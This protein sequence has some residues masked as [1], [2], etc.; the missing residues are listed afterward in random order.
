MLPKDFSEVVEMGFEPGSLGS[1][2][3]ILSKTTL[4]QMMF[5]AAS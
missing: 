1:Y 5:F 2:P 3:V 4:V